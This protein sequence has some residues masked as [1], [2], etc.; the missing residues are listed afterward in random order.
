M[1]Y[2][3]DSDFGGVLVFNYMWILIGFKKFNCRFV[4]M[5]IRLF[6]VPWNAVIRR[7]TGFVDKMR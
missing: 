3:I 6:Q 2:G 1:L 7:L 4:R 5:N